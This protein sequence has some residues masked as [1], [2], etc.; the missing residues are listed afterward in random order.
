MISVTVVTNTLDAIAGYGPN[1][2]GIAVVEPDISETELE[3]LHDGGMRG[4]RLNV[5]FGGGV[6]LH[7]LEPLAEKIA[8]LGWHLQLLLDAWGLCHTHECPSDLDDSGLVD[9][10]D[11]LLLLARWG[12]CA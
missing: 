2:R 6:G 8:P 7:A 12:Q 4:L 3:R 1:A 10:I 9:V 11:L 5:L